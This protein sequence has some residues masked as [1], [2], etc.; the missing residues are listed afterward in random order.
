MVVV[1]AAVEV[2]MVCS[3][4]VWCVWRVLLAGEAGLMEL[5]SGSLIGEQLEP[6]TVSA[7]PQIGSRSQTP[8]QV[9]FIINLLNRIGSEWQE[10]S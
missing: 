1:G 9:S 2:D 4:C 7:R 3:L 5:I 10:R 6:V 8:T